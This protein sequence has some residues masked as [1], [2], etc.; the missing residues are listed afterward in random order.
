[1]KVANNMPR[2]EFLRIPR[3]LTK[4]AGGFMAL[5]APSHV[6]DTRYNR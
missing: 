6:D 4:D 1:M 5:C 3:K 2:S